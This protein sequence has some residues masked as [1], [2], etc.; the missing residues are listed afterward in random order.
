M[1][2]YIKDFAARLTEDKA[3]I[4]GALCGDACQ[5]SDRYQIKLSV[6]WKDREFV[7]EFANCLAHDKIL[8]K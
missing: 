7:K 6:L 2:N 1:V 3:Y 4:I 5:K 8:D